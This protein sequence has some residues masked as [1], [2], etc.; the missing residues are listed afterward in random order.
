[1]ISR[2][3]LPTQRVVLEELVESDVATSVVFPMQTN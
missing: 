1:M 2:F 3:L